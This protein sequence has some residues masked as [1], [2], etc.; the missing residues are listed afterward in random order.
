MQN[1]I[2]S[3]NACSSGSAAVTP[4][5]TV[6]SALAP[7][8]A[9]KQMDLSMR[10]GAYEAICRSATPSTSIFMFEFYTTVTTTYSYPA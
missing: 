6:R 5:R 10:A 7:G 4:G 3:S 8:S 2:A 9:S 1:G